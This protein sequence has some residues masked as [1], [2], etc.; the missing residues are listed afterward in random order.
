MAGKVRKGYLRYFNASRAF[1]CHAL[2]LSLVF[3]SVEWGF[4]SSAYANPSG[5]TVVGGSA[6]ITGQGSGHVKINQSSNRAAINWNDF[7]VGAGERTQFIQ[8][9]KN[10]VAFN[11]VTGGNAS[12]ILGQVDA[13]GKIILA[14]P[15]GIVF[16]AGSKIDAAGLVA[17]THDADTNAFMAGGKLRFNKNPNAAT[18]AS[19]V[20]QG[21]ITIRDAGVAAFVAPAVRND[22][23]I[24][25]DAGKVA[26]GAGNGFTLDLSGNNLIAFKVSDQISET[27][28]DANG[29]PIRALVENNGTIQANGGKILLTATAARD[30]INQ[31]VNVGGV[32]KASNATQKGG[33]IILSSTNA[34]GQAS[35]KII[36]EDASIK[37]TGK[38]T[39]GAVKILG[40][41]VN[42]KNTAIDVSGKTGGGAVRIGGG[43][44]GGEGLAAATT[45]TVDAGTKIKANATSKGNGGSIVLW[46][47]IYTSYQGHLEARGGPNGGNGGQGEV[48]GKQVLDFTG[49]ADLSAVKGLRGSLLLDP[50]N[51]I[52]QNGGGSPGV[53]CT[54]GVCLPDGDSSYLDVAAIQDL[55]NAGTNVEISTGPNGSED[56]TIT[57]NDNIYWNTNS[58]LIVNAAFSILINGITIT[59]DYAGDEFDD[60]PVLLVMNS[61][62]DANGAGGIFVNNGAID[63]H[64]STG[65]V[66]IFYGLGSNGGSYTEGSLFDS[67][68][69]TAPANHSIH[70]QF[71][72]YELINTEADLIQT[73]STM[74]HY[75]ALGQN[76]DGHG[77]PFNHDASLDLLKSSVLDGQYCYFMSGSNCRIENFTLTPAADEYMVGLYKQIDS[78]SIVRNLGLDI[79][80]THSYALSVSP[81]YYLGSL[82]AYLE[83]IV[84]NVVS[85]GD[86]YFE[87]GAG[88]NSDVTAFVGGL[89]GMSK[90][91]DD[92]LIYGSQTQGYLETTSAV[93]NNMSM[94]LFQGGLLGYN[95]T[96]RVERSSSLGDTAFVYRGSSMNPQGTVLGGLIGYNQNASHLDNS[97]F[98]TFSIGD[99]SARYF[100]PTYAHDGGVV[101]T[102]L[103]GHTGFNAVDGDIFESFASGAVLNEMMYQGSGHQFT[104]GFVGY[105]EGIIKH[106]F[107]MGR[108]EY[109]GGDGSAY[110]GGFVGYNNGSIEQAYATGYGGAT[111]RGTINGF[112]ENGGQFRDVYFDVGTTGLDQGHN[113]GTGTSTKTL[114]M[115]LDVLR[116]DSDI[117]GLDS[118]RSYAYFLWQYEDARNKPQVISGYALE[119]H[120]GTTPT[121][122]VEIAG[123]M[124]GGGFSSILNNNGVVTTGANGYYY[125]LLAPGT[126]SGGE[127]QV[128]TYR[129]DGREGEAFM[130]N[131]TD[132]GI[133]NLNIYRNYLHYMTETS[134][135]FAE[136]MVDLATGLGSTNGIT[137]GYDISANS[138]MMPDGS[139][140]DLDI[141]NGATIDLD[142]DIN[143]G[144]GGIVDITAAENSAISQS[145][146]SIVTGGLALSGY[147]LEMDNA[148]NIFSTLAGS[149]DLINVATNGGFDIGTVN[150]STGLFGTYV[151]LSTPSTVTQS[152]MLNASQLLLGGGTG[153]Y[154]LASVDNYFGALAISAHTADLFSSYSFSI[155]AV[156]GVNGVTA[157]NLYIYSNGGTVTQTQGIF[158]SNLLL[159]GLGCYYYLTNTNNAITT[160]AADGGVNTLSFLENS[161]FNIGTV[162]GTNGAAATNIY[163]SSTGTVTQSQAISASSLLLQGTGATYT[164]TNTN[165]AITTLASSGTG[166]RNFL[167]NS[168]FAIGSVN[169]TVGATATNIYLSSSGTVTQSQGIFATGLLLQGSGTYTLTNTNNAITTLASSGTGTRNFTENS[170]YDIGTVNSVNGLTATNA[171]LSTTGTVTQSQGIFA[172]D[173]LLQGSGT[174]TLTNTNN[175]ITTL[176][177]SG[178]GTRNFLENSGFA[179]GSV[180][181]T[182]GATATNIYLSSSGTVTQ[183]Q[184]I[185]A[186]DL[187]LQGSG[188]YTLTNTNN[189][190]T[191]LASSGTGT[192]NFLENS[193][194]AIGSVNGT[195]GATATN[196]YLSSSGTVTQS[197]GIFATGLLLQGTGTYTLTNTNNAITTLAS[198]GTGTRNFTENSG[199]DIGTVNSVNGLTATNAY[200]ST[201]GTV[202]QSQSISVS[203]LLLQGAGGTYTLTNTSNAITTLAANT[204]IVN[205]REG[206][207][208]TIGGVN[209]TS[210]MTTTGKTTVVAGGAIV[211]AEDITANGAGTTIELSGTSF[212]NSA[213]S[214]LN[215]G[216]GRFLVWSANPAND[217]RGNLGYDFKHYNATYGVTNVSGI[218]GDG[219]L[220]TLAPTITAS[221]TGAVNRV[222]DGTDT[223]TLTA[224]NYSVSGEVDGDAVTLNNPASGIYNNKNV[225][226]AKNVAVT[227][228][229]IASV[230][231]GS[232]TV[233]GYQLNNTTADANIGAITAKALTI[234]TITADDKVYD[235]TTTAGVS[236]YTF[237]GAVGGDNLGMTGLAGLF[238]NKNVGNGK[239]V[240]ISAGTLTGTDKDNYTFT[241]GSATDTANITP[242]AL[243]IATIAADDK[244]YNGNTAAG[245]SGYTFGGAVGGDNLSMTGLSGVF[246]DKNADTGKT[247]TISAGT[248]AGTDKDNYTFTLGSATDTA[249][250]TAKA[251]TIASFTANNKAYDGSAAATISGYTF[252]GA[253]GGDILSVTGMTGTFN[254]ATAGTGKTVTLASGSLAG[255]DAG[256]YSFT[257]GVATALADITGGV[258]PPPPPPPPPEDV[259]EAI[260]SMNDYQN[261]I[262]Q[263]EAPA[264]PF[265]Q[266]AKSSDNI[267][268]KEDTKKEDSPE[269]IVN[270]VTLCQQKVS[271]GS[272]D[273]QESVID[274]YCTSDNAN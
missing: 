50:Q 107:A 4:I 19:V 105:N 207:G 241:L 126:L 123:L 87:Y 185:F 175:A 196:I 157:T 267:E 162:N 110:T 258:T 271:Q 232:A 115:D 40:E 141:S 150:E 159:R 130:Q 201:T 249:D 37:A 160:L 1:F 242:K 238:G 261:T 176:A 149:G 17:T 34:A 2:I 64:H 21:N 116:F 7:S 226:T 161:G 20:N 269:L 13:N 24:V 178:T 156:N 273:Q 255:A 251:L 155:A 39:G 180:N 32:L 57:I 46:S 212:D 33:E 165:N 10:A 215:A 15:N 222:Y 72:A 218:S 48:S 16:G 193:G 12:Q 14:N 62:A 146:G 81:E 128:L 266:P 237:G 121:I 68:S 152:Q 253:V 154:N 52:V 88:K 94:L 139:G 135:T 103:G 51:I 244:V 117:W 182:V 179:I 8:P 66:S 213:D 211:L 262:M 31:S 214:S 96:G 100:D 95:H 109:A 259:Q 86:I 78:G 55:L 98:Q 30:I 187:L 74:G 5:G 248:L 153:T 111:R 184:G 166:T 167:E 189:A 75:Y 80:I 227:S 240:T 58:R 231:D 254:N 145:S 177:S 127:D 137:I 220:Y 112:G 247:V 124:N 204:G 35:G 234:A 63:F 257:L 217:D 118:T 199:Y 169:G 83:G 210:G 209:G 272:E 77:S 119:D 113:D 151:Y 49:T 71:T 91:N 108:T 200:L 134:G 45:T 97:V 93:G 132:A 171:Y 44:K 203:D 73:N 36:V 54:D 92:T 120:Q 69:W 25:A 144:S 202:T 43:F 106:A 186:T 104:G 235:G 230:S 99:V 42:V 195:V 168:G 229:A 76:I 224:G 252:G 228:I 221:L 136:L 28:T 208:L 90:G 143:V 61:D 164:L 256:N 89:V 158:V 264:K 101:E 236:G 53:T 11:R 172:T 129:N 265:A 22:G 140:F 59:N 270:A 82:T 173:L 26:M 38:T 190:I 219:F 85:Y 206:N 18:G 114:Q 260:H 27:V 188:T 223:A 191:T 239:T 194:F 41:H 197:Q 147:M 56:G 23:V 274:L 148:A 216:T 243:T 79:D 246:A 183:S 174:Y 29:N 131:A 142:K 122:D 181:G 205:Y 163:L 3:S 102:W 263:P 67:A 9:N 65:A 84:A 125:F 225:G 60:I 233:Y 47:D 250:I 192:R 268:K 70:R 133:R 170:G 198:S 138:M 6:T 245:I